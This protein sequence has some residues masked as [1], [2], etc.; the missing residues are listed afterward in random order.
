M[1][2]GEKN[3][4]FKI[5]EMKREHP[6]DV[7]EGYFEAFS[8]RVSDLVKEEE[9][10]GSLFRVRYLKPVVGIVATVAAIL[11]LV[12]LPFNE[13]LSGYIT[14]DDLALI[15]T[16]NVDILESFLSDEYL[17][18]LGESSFIF[19]IDEL[20]LSEEDKEIDIDELEDYIASNYSDFEILEGF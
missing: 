18:N 19:T 4:R 20:M 17:E 10:S 6:F 9:A 3:K 5:S 16:E 7:P 13:F 2:E 12:F 15:K 14:D 8:E 11:L 1:G